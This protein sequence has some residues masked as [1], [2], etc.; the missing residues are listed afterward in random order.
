MESTEVSAK[1]QANKKLAYIVSDIRIPF[2]DIMARGITGAASSKSYDV[3]VYSSDNNKKTELENIIK[4]IR[5]K[6]SGII[7]SPINSS[8]AVTLLKLAKK[9][10]I[11]VVIS[12]IGTDSGEYIS[13]ISSNNKEGAYKIGKVLAKKMKEQGWDRDGSVGIV[14]IPQKRANGKARTAGFMKAMNEAGIKAA[15]L[16]QQVSFSYQET[17]D[18]SIELIE[19]NSDLRALW[20]QGSDRY[21]GALDAIKDAGK[22]DDIFLICFDAEPVFLDFIPNG[23]IVG[24]AMQ[25]PYLMGEEAVNVMNK[26]LN[27]NKVEKNLQLPVLAISTANIAQ[28][29]PIIKRNV[30]GI[31]K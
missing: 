19:K 12:D 30:L 5:D 15:G 4:V 31:V 13:Y 20:L 7:I 21:Q 8:T 17:Y 24:A 27:G 9:A 10:D 1:E 25:Q 18:F 26:H 11:P 29:L 22:K 3:E 6:P 14:A 2:W 16:R 28:K 23:T